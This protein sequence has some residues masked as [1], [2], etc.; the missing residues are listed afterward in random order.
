VAPRLPSSV[1]GVPPSQGF[2]GGAPGWTPGL[3]GRDRVL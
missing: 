2:A 3:R 1:P